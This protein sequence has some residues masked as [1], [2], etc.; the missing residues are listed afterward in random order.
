MLEN[1]VKNR[2]ERLV[3]LNVTAQS[4]IENLRG[5][6]PEYIFTFRGRP[7]LHM[8][9]TAWKRARKKVGLGL[10]RVHDLKH[11]F[12]RRLRSVGVGFKDRQDLLGHKSNRITTHYSAAELDKLIEAANRVCERGRQGPVLTLLRRTDEQKRAGLGVTGSHKTR[13]TPQQ[14]E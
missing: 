7:V 2:E 14:R 8:N 12:S 6:H 13:T 3:V 10:V 4:I 5:V 9:N 1:R 11:T